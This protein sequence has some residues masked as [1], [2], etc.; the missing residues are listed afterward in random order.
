MASFML[1]KSF[2]RRKSKSSSALMSLG[3]RSAASSGLLLPSP[4]EP[5]QGYDA[6][7]KIGFEA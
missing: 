2:S 5:V 7:W 4:N 1:L 3:S 6:G